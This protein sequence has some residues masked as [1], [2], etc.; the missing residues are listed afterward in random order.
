MRK[1]VLAQLGALLVLAGCGAS[2]GLDSRFVAVHNAMA[3]SGL[4]QSGAI[5]QGRLDEGGETVVPMTLNVGGCYTIVGLGEPSD[6]DVVVRDASG[7]ELARD[8]SGD[9]Q[10]ATRFCPT[11]PGVYS[12]AVRATHGSGSWVASVWS[13]SMSSSD[14]R[15]YVPEPGEAPRPPPHGGPGTC[16]RPFELA[17]GQTARGDSS[18][19]DSVTAGSCV[20]GSEAPE[21]VYAFNVDSRSMVRA[22]LNTLYD[23]ALYILGTCGEVRSELV[24]NDDAPSTERSEVGAVLEPGVYYLVVDGF[25]SAAGEYEVALSATPTRSLGE[26]CQSAI[27]LSPGRRVAGTTAGEPN[28]FEASCAGGA[29]SGDRVY[30]LEVTQTSRLRAELQSTFDGAL[31]LR[32]TCLAQGSEIACNDDSPDTQHSV[33]T[34]TVEPG[35]YYL[36]AD[37]YGRA[38]QGDFSLAAELFP[39]TGPAPA[40]DS[41]SN[42]LPLA[43]GSTTANTLPA[44]D[45]VAVSCGGQGAADLIYRIEARTRSRIVVHPN[46]SQFAPALSLQSSCGGTEISCAVGGDID[47]VVAPGTYFLVVDGASANDF[48]SV[49]LNVQVE[50]L[51]VVD[52]LCRQ[53][54]TLRAGRQVVGDTT[55]QPDRFQAS[56]GGSAHGPELVYQLR[57]RRTQH[58]VISSEQSDFDGVLHVRR[59]CQDANSEVACND[60]AGD[61]HHSLVDVVL[62][63]GTYF[64]FMDG[65]EPAA[66]G[67]FTLDVDLTNP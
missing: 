50:D 25:G 40:G 34:A 57:L 48:G 44:R 64:V 33:V 42:A 37:G 56:C 45:D 6:L 13:D 16:E 38:S 22:T 10:A 21:H 32:R 28:L 18:T 4:V 9:S 39:L 58:V 7:R 8:A 12:V 30:S 66:H 60:D 14:P 3:A 41:C 51:A 61:N 1:T 43:A 53:A 49:E 29:Q 2:S 59:A 24:C 54:P 62:P 47:Q 55:A 63:A 20:E 46:A 67:H 26:V 35:T 27:P 36:I 52:Q 11:Y 17:I 65:Y 19:G 15:S 5:S 23:G 31:Y